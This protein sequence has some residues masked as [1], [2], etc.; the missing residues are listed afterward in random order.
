M[1]FVI[2]TQKQDQWCWAA[3]SA[4]VDQY[5][6]AQTTSSQC[7]IAQQVLGND[8]CG[9][10]EPCNQP[11]FLD[12]ALKKVGRLRE[13]RPGFLSFEQAKAEIQKGFPIGVRI[14]WFGGGGHFLLIS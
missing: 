2:Q 14:G 1:P 7:S 4:T 10:M 13:V 6:D 3:V 12:E 5:F 9:A 11:Y 8:C